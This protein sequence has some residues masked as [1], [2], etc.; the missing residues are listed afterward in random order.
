MNGVFSKSARPNV[1]MDPSPQTNKK[2]RPYS[3]WTFLDPVKTAAFFLEIGMVS[4]KSLDFP[5][6]PWSTWHT[7]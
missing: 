7:G 6:V 5:Q 3:V 2:G 4:K 1:F